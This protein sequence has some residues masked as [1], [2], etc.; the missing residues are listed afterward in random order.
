MLVSVAGVAALV[1]VFGALLSLIVART[2][3]TPPRRRSAD[4]RVLA[5]DG[6]ASVVTL[7]ATADS[8]LPGRYSFFFDGERGSA[9]IGDIISLGA[10]TVTRTVIDV[11]SGDLVVGARGR[12]SGWYYN[13]P[14]ELGFPSENVE[15]ATELGPA[16][17]WLVPAAE[18]TDRWMIAVHGR[19]V[20]RQETVR[21][22]PVFRESGYTSLLISYRN[23]GDAPASEDRRYAL[24]D[25][26]W[27]DVDVAVEYAIAHGA[28]AIVLMGWSMG[29]ATVLQELTRSPHAGVIRGLVLDSP[30]IDWATALR[31]QGE[32]RRL[33]EPVSEGALSI[34]GTN[35]G[36]RLTGQ[37]VAIDLP[38]LDFVKRAGELHVPI[39]LMHSDDDGYVPVTASRA[40][41]AAR[42]DIVTF[43]AFA[44][45]AHTKLWNFD[46]VRWNSAI[47]QW[48]AVL[49]LNGT[50]PSGH[51]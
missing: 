31:F 28:K 34:I 38:R 17:A 44:V 4:I 41:A 43:E 12:F 27:H 6:G 21:A 50:P 5:I 30:V 1:T 37:G 36:R 35:W 46:P 33:P 8:R 22:V 10:D 45:A 11:S 14:G 23:D 25:T 42:P 9:R 26:E 40:L 49:P 19:A 18:P 29:G 13:D 16:P 39:L 51:N 7:S 24:G 15:L 3:V 47:S 2:V 48:L 32:L 20:R